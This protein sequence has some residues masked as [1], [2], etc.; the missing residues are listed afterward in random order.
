MKEQTKSFGT[1]YVP[2]M[3]WVDQMFTETTLLIT[4]QVDGYGY[5]EPGLEEEWYY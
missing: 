1:Q 4:S 2:P 3:V 5:I